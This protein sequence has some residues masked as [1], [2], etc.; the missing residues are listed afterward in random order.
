MKSQRQKWKTRIWRARGNWSRSG[1]RSINEIRSWGGSECGDGL[2]G[3]S[4]IGKWVWS[5]SKS[6]KNI[7][8]VSKS[9]NKNYSGSFSESGNFPYFHILYK[10]NR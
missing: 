5:Y 10:W 3:W 6:G 2:R 8:E 4:E 1:N 9:G 7:R